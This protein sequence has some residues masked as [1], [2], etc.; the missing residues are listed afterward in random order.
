M[1]RSPYTYGY[2]D[3]NLGH[4]N[5]WQPDDTLLV[6]PFKLGWEEIRA[7]DVMR[8]NLNGSVLEGVWSVTPIQRRYPMTAPR[9][10]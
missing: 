6:S 3:H 7:S 10:S 5:Y 4:I 2:D 8:I 1:S 9:S